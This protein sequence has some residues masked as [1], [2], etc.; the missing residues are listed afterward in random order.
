MITFTE[1]H[2]RNRV[3][4]RSYQSN[5]KLDDSPKRNMKNIV[6]GI[7]DNLDITFMMEINFILISNRLQWNLNQQVEQVERK[8][9]SI[10]P[11]D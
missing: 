3:T 1:F 2:L 4:R 11:K 5:E 9:N 6:I 10:Q 8:E 7:F